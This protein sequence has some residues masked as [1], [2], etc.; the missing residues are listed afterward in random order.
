MRAVTLSIGRPMV[1]WVVGSVGPRIAA[2]ASPEVSVE[3]YRLTIVACGLVARI[4]AA[5]VAVSGSPD[6]VIT[7]RG[8]RA[9]A[10]RWVS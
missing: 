10:S 3:P 2:V 8:A 9:R 4:V 6:E 5:R 7:R 1:M